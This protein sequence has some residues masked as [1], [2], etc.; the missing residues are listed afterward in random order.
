MKGGAP[1]VAQ[2]PAR[3]KKLSPEFATH[4]FYS[5]VGPMSSHEQNPAFSH[6]VKM[7]A[8]CLATAAVLAVSIIVGF[9]GAFELVKTIGSR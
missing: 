7:F 3:I 5:K 2:A 4:E 9:R 1:M 8:I 6:H